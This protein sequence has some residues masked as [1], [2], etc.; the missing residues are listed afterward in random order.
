MPKF[1]VSQTEGQELPESVK[2]L[3]GH[4]ERGVFEKLVKVAESMGFTVQV[5]PEIEGH[6]GANGLCEY[7]PK[8]LTVAGN[9]S[10]L[11]QVKSLTHEIAHAMLHDPDDGRPQ[12][13]SREQCELEAESTTHITCQSLGLDTSDYSFGYVAGWAG[14]EA[15]KTREAIKASGHRISTASRK[16][17]DELNRQAEA[18]P[19]AVP[20]PECQG[21]DRE[22]ELV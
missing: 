5:T 13:I 17:C 20:E 9:R 21:E 3:D 2:L 4:D 12:A 8:R 19:E 15:E 16:I 11:Q 6:P 14:G 1:D 22:P 7:T 18:E 10:K